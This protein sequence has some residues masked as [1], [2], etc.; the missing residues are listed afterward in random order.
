M[1][2]MEGSVIYQHMKENIAW[3]VNIYSTLFPNMLYLQVF[4]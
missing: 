3:A 2:D 1:L 4:F